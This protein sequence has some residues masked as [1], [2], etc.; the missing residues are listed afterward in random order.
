MEIMVKTFQCDA[1]KIAIVSI[2]QVKRFV[3]KEDIINRN[4][5]VKEMKKKWKT[6]TKQKEDKK[7]VKHLSWA[8]LSLIPIQNPKPLKIDSFDTNCTTCSREFVHAYFLCQPY[9]YNIL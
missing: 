6:K 3:K 2:G 5:N 7:T 1:L 8:D 4:D 9:M